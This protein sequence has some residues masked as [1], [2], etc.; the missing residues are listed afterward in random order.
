MLD[1]RPSQRL[2]PERADLRADAASRD[3]GASAG[4]SPFWTSAVPPPRHA[5]L[6]ST[7]SRR[8]NSLMRSTAPAGRCC[9]GSYDDHSASALQ[10]PT[11]PDVGALAYLRPW[12]NASS[13]SASPLHPVL[14]ASHHSGGCCKA[15]INRRYP[16]PRY[17]QPAPCSSCR[18]SS[19]R[20]SP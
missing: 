16:L 1:G 5:R 8:P 7:S 14:S 11:L 13:S 15:R 2:H 20:P 6:R 12:L 9:S 17:T 3:R 19:R 18:P 4:E 10:L